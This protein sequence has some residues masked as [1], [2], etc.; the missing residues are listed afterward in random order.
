M[1]RRQID[2]DMKPYFE[3][4]EAILA[5]SDMHP[6]MAAAIMQFARLGAGTDLVD[7]LVLQQ[8]PS[9]NVRSDL[10][11]T[12]Q[13]ADRLGISEK[14]VYRLLS[15]GRLA[16]YGVG[17]Q[18]RF[19]IADLDALISQSRSATRLTRSARTDFEERRAA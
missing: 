1:K 4:A 17:R 14:Q 3:D 11:S 10:L 18:H 15:R 8:S 16:S 5:A 19:R 2:I 9:A 12:R 7:L 6:V 13:A